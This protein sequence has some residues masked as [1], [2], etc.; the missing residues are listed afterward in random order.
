[1]EGVAMLHQM[2]IQ[3]KKALVAACVITIVVLTSCARSNPTP[4][5]PEHIISSVDNY[6]A[7]ASREMQE[8]PVGEYVY[9]GLIK[10]YAEHGLKDRNGTSGSYALQATG[11]VIAVDGHLYVVTPVHVIV[12]NPLTESIKLPEAKREIPFDTIIQTGARVAIGYT[13]ITPSAIWLPATNDVEEV[14]IL[15]IPDKEYQNLLPLIKRI[16]N[17]S[18]NPSWQPD[19]SLLRQKVEMWGLPPEKAQLKEGA[20]SGVSPGYLTINQ[21]VDNGYSGG[22]IVLLGSDA[23]TKTVI[24]MITSVKGEQTFARSWEIIRKA[25]DAAVNGSKEMVKVEPN[26]TIAYGSDF[27]FASLSPGNTLFTFTATLQDF[28]TL[29][30]PPPKKWW[31]FWK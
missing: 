29:M 31:E 19:I 3:M 6:P 22:T 17:T 11:Q 1:M 28:S 27:F 13:G 25:L 20:I 9:M 24:G 4:R 30:T 14:A 18:I 8:V 12:P 16:P 21:P 23:V 5:V 7:A 2:E 10:V 26:Q 15:V